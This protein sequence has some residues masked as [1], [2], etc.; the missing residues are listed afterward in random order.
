[1]MQRAVVLFVANSIIRDTDLHSMKRSEIA[2]DDEGMNI[3]V[4][5]KK[6][7]NRGQWLS[8][9]R[10]NEE[11]ICP[12]KALSNWLDIVRVKFPIPMHCGTTSGILVLLNKEFAI[13]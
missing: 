4:L 7:K 3:V 10:K 8:Y 1:M 2:L 12:V 6:T 11:S 13:N 9:R 5:K